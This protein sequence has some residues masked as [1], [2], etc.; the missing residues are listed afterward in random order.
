[1]KLSI[2]MPALRSRRQMRQGLE[3]SLVRQ[4]REF[5]DVEL[6]I[7]EDDGH[8]PSGEKRNRL[9][10]RS[11]G[12]YFA[13]VDD[14]DWISAGYVHHLRAGC[15]T[16]ADLVSFRVR[17][18]DPRKPTRL[19]VFSIHHQDKQR[20]ADGKLGMMANHLCAWRREV[21][22]AVSFPPNLG[23]NDD[24]F[25]Y[26]PLLASG[27]V[28]KETHVPH[29]LYTYRFDPAVT[30]NERWAVKRATYRWA[31]RGIECFRRGDE[32]LIAAR[33]IDRIGGRKRIPVRD[34]WGRLHVVPRSE[35]Q[36]Y[37]VCK[38]A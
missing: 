21:G 19:H 11:R 1:M 31:G 5:D 15:L 23:Y 3:A 27:L 29:V 24:V 14:D 4:S 17:R 32:V 38:A 22:G 10:Q 20:L 13:F 37:F 34:R 16:G 35:L 12:A 6:L 25:W 8:A 2:L 9:V 33:S 18:T 28:K 36:R 30:A 7:E 26:K